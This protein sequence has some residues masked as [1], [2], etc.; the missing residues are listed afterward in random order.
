MRWPWSRAGRSR[1]PT[2]RARHTAGVAGATWA[3]AAAPPGGAV[4]LGFADGSELGLGAEDPLALALT[5]VADVLMRQE[6]A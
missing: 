6:R 5:A 3:Q 2:A 4:H 1:Q